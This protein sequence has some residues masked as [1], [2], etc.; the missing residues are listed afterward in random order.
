MQFLVIA[1]DGKDAGASERRLAARDA[2][3]AGARRRKA[4][5]RTVAGGAILDDNGQMIGSAIIVN[6]PSRTELD[7]WLQSDPYVT[8]GVWVD[9]Q[10]QPFR[11]AV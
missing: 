7:E 11:Q 10:V 2:H 9:I 5:G 4:E 8:G 6:Y 3:L 1:Y